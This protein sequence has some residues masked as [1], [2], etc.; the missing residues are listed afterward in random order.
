MSMIIGFIA[1]VVVGVVGLFSISAIMINR[2]LEY[3]FKDVH[4]E[5]NE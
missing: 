3:E 4:E 5:D 2:D 1:G